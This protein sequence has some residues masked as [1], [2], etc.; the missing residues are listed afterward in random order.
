MQWPRVL[1]I[2]WGNRE[3]SVWSQMVRK[4]SGNS[5][6]KLWSTFRGTP[7][8]RSEQNSRNFLT[9]CE[10][11]QFP[12]S[13]Q[14]KTIKGNRSANG[15]RHLVRLVCWF[16]KNPY[17]YSMLVPTGLFWQMVSTPILSLRCPHRQSSDGSCIPVKRILWVPCIITLY[18]AQLIS[19]HVA[20]AAFKAYHQQS[21]S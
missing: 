13:H 17:H 1:T 7:L 14:L 16:W 8:F 20:Y 2:W 5:I 19:H 3:I 18:K 9:I 6:W 21:H 12:D 11:F 4:F 10:T 15:K